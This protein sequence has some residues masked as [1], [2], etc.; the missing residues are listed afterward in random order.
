MPAITCPDLANE[1][2][3]A[4]DRLVDDAVEFEGIPLVTG[5]DP[6][7]DAEIDIAKT[8]QQIAVSFGLQSRK[9]LEDQRGELRVTL[10]WKTALVHHKADLIALIVA[11]G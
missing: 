5:L 2:F 10:P 3:T 7:R 11:N 8:L 6:G 4:A 9:W 1:P